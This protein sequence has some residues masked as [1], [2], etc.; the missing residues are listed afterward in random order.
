M[1][2]ASFLSPLPRFYLSTPGSPESFCQPACVCP[3]WQEQGLQK[4]ESR[5]GRRRLALPLAPRV[6]LGGSTDTS[7]VQLRFLSH[8]GLDTPGENEVVSLWLQAERSP[9]FLL[10]VMPCARRLGVGWGLVLLL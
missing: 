4:P 9:E 10:C 3:A 1:A 5:W 8:H 7:R 6:T 2:L